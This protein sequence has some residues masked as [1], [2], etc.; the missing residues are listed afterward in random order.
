VPVC[1]RPGAGGHLV[2]TARVHLS[3]L[4]VHCARVSAARSRPPSLHCASAFVRRAGA[5][6]PVVGGQVQEYGR[7]QPA[8]SPDCMTITGILWRPRRLGQGNIKYG[9]KRRS[10]TWR[11]VVFDK[12]LISQAFNRR[13]KAVRL[14]FCPPKS[15]AWLP[16][17]GTRRRRLPRWSQ[18]QECLAFLKRE[19]SIRT[20]L[21]G[22]ASADP[23]A[24]LTR[25]VI[26]K[27]RRRHLLKANAVTVVL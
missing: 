27:L 18:P 3:A 15:V 8:R 22:E 21:H 12:Y 16:S 13:I 17:W 10:R 2:C 24:H 5:L 20:F 14:G 11:D 6:C 4:R 23:D 25:W 19:R 26:S 7:H 1:R 9:L